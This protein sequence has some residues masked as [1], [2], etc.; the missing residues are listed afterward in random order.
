MSPDP[1]ETE[2]EIWRECAELFVLT[3]ELADQVAAQVTEQDTDAAL[4]RILKRV[5]EE[6]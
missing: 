6:R 3:G 5:Q 1:E 4:Q 2:D